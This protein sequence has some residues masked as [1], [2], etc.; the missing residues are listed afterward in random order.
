[1][2]RKHNSKLKKLGAGL[3]IQSPDSRKWLSLGL[4]VVVP[5]FSS[6]NERGRV[7]FLR[8][9][10]EAMTALSIT[11]SE[12]APAKIRVSRRKPWR[13]FPWLTKKEFILIEAFILHIDVGSIPAVSVELLFAGATS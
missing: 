13:Y 6:E 9:D 3:H 12:A 7:S 11:K 1:M 8:P 10:L 4:P 2:T 5:I